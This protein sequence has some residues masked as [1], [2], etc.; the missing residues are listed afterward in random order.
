MI[1]ASGKRTLDCTG[2]M[3]ASL[4]YAGIIFPSVYPGKGNFAKKASSHGFKYI[5]KGSQVATKPGDIATR[6]KGSGKI[7][8]HYMVI[9]GNNTTSEVK[10]TTIKPSTTKTEYFVSY[11]SDQPNLITSKKILTIIEDWSLL[12]EYYPNQCNKYLIDVQNKTDMNITS[13]IK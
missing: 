10:Q 6:P 12:N 4:G 1:S 8:G 11:N 2:L 9:I 7:S 13:I 3:R 5:G